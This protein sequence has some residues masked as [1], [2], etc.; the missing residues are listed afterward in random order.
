MQDLNFPRQESFS[1][2]PYDRDNFAQR[3]VQ[4]SRGSHYS[5]SHLS[6]PTKLGQ[7][8]NGT[9]QLPF[10]RA[11]SPG[12]LQTRSNRYKN[13]ARCNTRNLQMV[14]NESRSKENLATTLLKL[15]EKQSS[16]FTGTDSTLQH[17]ITKNAVFIYVG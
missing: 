11:Y 13:D 8:N 10:G 15:Y 12:R 1:Q 17:G 2:R 5:P 6:E 14:Q 4:N 7:E 16:Q 9:E 3:N